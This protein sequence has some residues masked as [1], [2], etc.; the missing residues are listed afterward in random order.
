MQSFI[1]NLKEYFA[2]P[3]DTCL[4]I[5]DMVILAVVT[6]L[7]CAFLRKNNAA[8][9]IKLFAAATI[10]GVCFYSLRDKMPVT[11]YIM[12]FVVLIVIFAYFTMFPH[13]LKRGLWKIASPRESA[14]IYTAKYDCSYEELQQSVTEIVK[15]VQNMS[16]RNV[17]ALIVIA[18]DDLPM[19]IIEIGRAHV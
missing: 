10:I 4:I 8:R 17:G 7:M 11:G 5:L 19:H 15:A 1:N 18:T 14:G 3:L 13:E 6:Y 12:S 2:T 9:L 16:K